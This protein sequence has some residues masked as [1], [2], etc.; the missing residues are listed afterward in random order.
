MNET[1]TNYTIAESFVLPSNGIIYDT[2]VNPNVT[3]RSMTARD[4][5]KRLAPSNT[6]FKVLSDIIEGCMVEPPK[7]HVYDM[8]LADYEYLLH[9]LRVVT[10]GD[11]YLMSL[12]CPDC[13]NTFNTTT[14]LDQLE[15]KQLD[16]TEWQQV[17]QIVLPKTGDK[18]TLHVQTPRLIEQTDTLAKDMKRKFKDATLNFQTLANLLLT[19]DTVNGKKLSRF[20]LQNYIDRLPALDLQ[21]ILKA[22]DAMG[23]SFGILNQVHVTCP[24]CG[25]EIVTFFRLGT[26]FFRPST[27]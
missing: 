8:A 17:S 19:I 26:E 2:Q 10:Y 3:L 1:Q 16:A 27:I 5:M 7:V 24:H 14:H 9:R 6:P 21:K 20:D 12:E 4:E 11:E 22:K 15:V 23:T 25:Q 18:L 13:A